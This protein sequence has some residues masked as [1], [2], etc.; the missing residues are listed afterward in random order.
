MQFKTRKSLASRLAI[1]GIADIIVNLPGKHNGKPP[2]RHQPL[3]AHSARWP[4]HLRQAPVRKRAPSFLGKFCGD[5]V[6]HDFKYQVLVGVVS[7]EGGIIWA[8]DWRAAIITR[9]APAKISSSIPTQRKIP[10]VPSV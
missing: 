8:G 1:S 9:A 7:L 4:P 6:S 10:G 5:P 3:G 2:V